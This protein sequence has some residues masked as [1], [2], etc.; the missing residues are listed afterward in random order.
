MR[1]IE[2]TVL[3]LLE[4]KQAKLERI[5]ADY[6]AKIADARALA[7]PC[8]HPVEAQMAFDWEHDNG[9]GVQSWHTGARC[10]ICG[11][12]NSWPGSSNNWHGG[13]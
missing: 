3:R 11:A 6:D 10:R 1:P 9:Y 5:A 13:E 8:T 12:T 4:E 2:K 7:K